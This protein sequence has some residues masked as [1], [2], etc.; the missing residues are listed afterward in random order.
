VLAAPL[1]A[2]DGKNLGVLYVS[3]RRSGE[4]SEEDESLLVQLAQLASIAIQNCVHAEAREANRLKDE[5]LATLSHELRNPLA[6]ISN[7]LYLLS[8]FGAHEARPRELRQLI[9]RH[10]DYLTRLV[11]DLLDVSRI[12]RGL[13]ELQRQPL[14]LAAVVNRA[15]EVNRPLIEGRRHELTVSLAPETLRVDADPVRLEQVLTNLLSNAAKYT[16]PGG[17]IRLSV[18]RDG[19]EG[20]LR[21]EDTGSGISPELL[22]RVFDLFTQAERSYARTHGGLGIGLHIVKRL[23]ELH[24][25]TVTAHSAGAGHGSEFVVRLPLTAVGPEASAPPIRNQR[26]G[27][28]RRILIIEDDRD[29][30]DTLREI[31]ELAG[32]NVASAATGPEG[33]RAAAEYSPDV[34]LCDIGLPGMDGYAVAAELR[35]LAATAQKPLIAVTGFGQEEDRRRSRAAGF[36]QHLTKPLDLEELLRLVAT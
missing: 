17:K 35:R 27:S 29:S 12:T 6:G 26:R 4:F 13:V 5:F 16:E 32:H 22:P 20:V 1:T 7:A 19:G 30:A 9:Q 25:G 24:G 3:D 36:D 28:G 18:Q 15:V 8:Q 2:S 11:A 34:V 21:V 14:D 33:V 10:T 23:V 31:L